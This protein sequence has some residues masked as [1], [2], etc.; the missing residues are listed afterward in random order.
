M[1]IQ[2]EMVETARPKS[3]NHSF[4]NKENSVVSQEMADNNASIP[5]CP[6]H[7][8]PSEL[9]NHSNNPAMT[10]G[11]QTTEVLALQN[12][13]NYKFLPPQFVNNIRS[14]GRQTCLKEEARR[15]VQTNNI[16]WHAE[17]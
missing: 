2:D 6:R 7:Q 11:I 4:D 3:T 12:P 14:A 1:R 16:L 17:N 13:R 9:G 8:K 10:I 15:D 5:F